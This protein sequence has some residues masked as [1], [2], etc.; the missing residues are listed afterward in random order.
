MFG[1]DGTYSVTDGTMFD[2]TSDNAECI[3]SDEL[4]MYN[5]ISVGDVIT[6]ANPDC[7]EEIYNVTV[8]GIYT[9]S[10]SDT[11]NSRFAFSDPANN[12]YMN[13]AA[14]QSI[15]NNSAKADNTASAVLTAETSFTYVLSSADRYYAFEESAKEKGL[16]ENYILSSSYL[17]AYEQSISLLETLSTM[18]GLFFIIVLII[19]GIILVVLNIFNLRERKYEVG[20]LTAIGMKKTK[21][22][23]QFVCELFIITFTAIIIGTGIGAT[24]SVPVTN[25]LLE[26]Q[27]AEIQESNE[28]V[29]QN[30][31]MGGRGN[32]Q[33]FMKGGNFANPQSAQSVNY[34]DSVS[35]ATDFTMNQKSER[36]QHEQVK[37]LFGNTLIFAIGQTSA[38]ILGFLLIRIY[39]AVLTPDQ[40]ST[41]ELLYNTLNILYPIVSFSMADAILR[42][43]VDKSYDIRKVYSSDQVS[44]YPPTRL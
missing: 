7:A 41:A 26:S 12:I 29:D 43:G 34:I 27:I 36:K 44:L 31:G 35:S 20:V 42:F 17:S 39:T 16:P 40:Y 9:N 11:G 2:E 30:Y 10:A 13:T 5:N 33:S 18:T 15:L 24:V 32:G 23:M 8:S 19:G 1:N 28:E 22:T 4:A 6:L 38:K 25:A 21:V 14:L 37:K 3:I